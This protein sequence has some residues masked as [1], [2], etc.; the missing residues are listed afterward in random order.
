MTRTQWANEDHR[1]SPTISTLKHSNVVGANVGVWVGGGILNV[2][3]HVD[4]R[5]RYSPSGITPDPVRVESDLWFDTDTEEGIKG[6]EEMASSFI[7]AGKRLEMLV[8]WLEE[9]EEPEDEEPD[10]GM[11]G[12]EVDARTDRFAWQDPEGAMD[13]REDW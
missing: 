8:A 4:H 3:L 5:P 2:S 11:A 10:E 9:D 6:L 12:D 13:R 1:M 7:A